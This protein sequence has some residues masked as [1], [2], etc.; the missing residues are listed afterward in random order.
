MDADELFEEECDGNEDDVLENMYYTAKETKNSNLERAIIEFQDVVAIEK[1]MKENGDWGFRSI[2]QIMKIYYKQK[3]FDKFLKIYQDF[4]HFVK[5]VVSR[6][7]G[8]RSIMNILDYML[9]DK[10]IELF[11]LICKTTINFLKNVNNQ[12]LW[13]RIQIKLAKLYLQNIRSNE[14]T[15]YQPLKNTINELTSFIDS[16]EC[17]S[18]YKKSTQSLEINALRIQLDNIEGNTNNLKKIFEES[19][20]INSAFPHPQVM[21]VIRECGGRMYL[22][23]EQYGEAH[24]NFLEAFKCYDESGSFQR[25][26]CLKYLIMTNMLKKSKMNP[27]HL[28]E[29]SPYKN[30]KEII[31]YGNLLNCYENNDLESFQSIFDEN[32]KEFESLEDLSRNHLNEIIENIRINL[33]LKQLRQVEKVEIEEISSF[34]FISKE[35]TINLLLKCLSKNLFIGSIDYVSNELFVDNV[36]KE[37]N[38]FL[39][40]IPSNSDTLLDMNDDYSKI[41]R[42]AS[43]NNVDRLKEQLSLY[44][45]MNNIYKLEER[46]MRSL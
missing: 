30:D 7:Y 10:N 11:Q 37:T 19:I 33:L 16:S 46:M 2:K 41:L 26:I 34:L 28:Q 36:P 1:D 43:S 22:K 42:I 6:N 8:E 12:R 18:L 9:V 27:F 23:E 5:S 35:K 25:M 21:A 45:Y 4:L 44:S 20:H 14:S 15:D 39:Q 32:R 40:N 3:E 31:V 24:D 17:S 29:V 38:R 13:F